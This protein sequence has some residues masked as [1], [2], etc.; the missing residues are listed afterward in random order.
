VLG[1]KTRIE[2][3]PAFAEV[4]CIPM[5]HVLQQVRS[6]PV[7]RVPVR[8]PRWEHEE[9]DPRHGLVAVYESWLRD[10]GGLEFIK[11]S[12]HGWVLSVSGRSP[13]LPPLRVRARP[14]T[15]A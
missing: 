8:G 14:V 3:T 4:F 9:Y 6:A 10:D 11:Y 2:A 1:Q 12:P 7:T 13:R 15:T 5:G